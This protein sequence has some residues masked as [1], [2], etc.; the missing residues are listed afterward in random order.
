MSGHPGS[1]MNAKLY[2]EINGFQLQFGKKPCIISSINNRRQSFRHGKWN[3]R[4][5]F[6]SC[7]KSWQDGKVI[8]V[9]PDLQ[10][11][12]VAV[13]KHLGG[14]KNIKFVHGES[15]SQFPHK[16]EEFYDVYFSNFV[17]R[18]LQPEEKKVFVDTAFRCLKP[19]GII[20]I[21]SHE[22]Y[23]DVIRLATK[24]FQNC[25]RTKIPM[26]TVTKAA[27]EKLL[28]EQNFAIVSSEYNDRAYILPSAQ[29][30]LSF[31]CASDYYDESSL[32]PAMKAE[33]FSEISS[34]DGTVAIMDPSIFQAIAKKPENML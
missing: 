6:I 18:W 5:H 17:F 22:S 32:S 31:F 29:R 21:Q 11:I 4:A 8:G 9:D 28:Q 26:Y 25:T 10:R 33:L 23:P 16:N 24:Y 34:P 14:H 19:G 3:W 12:K 7:S 2:S 13:H 20:A 15:S 1:E 27:T 30:F